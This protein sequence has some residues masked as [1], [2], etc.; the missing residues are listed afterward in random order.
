MEVRKT[1]RKEAREFIMEHHYTGTCGGAVMT[2]GLFNKYTDELLGAIAFQTP[3]SE[4]V[5]AYIFE[6]MDPSDGGVNECECDHFDEDHKYRQHVTELQRLVTLD[7]T[8][9]NTESWFIS[10]ALSKLKDHKPKYWAVVSFADTTEGHEGTIYKASNAYYYGKASARKFY[11]NDEG[12]L[13]SPRQGGV[14]IT[15]PEAREKGW[16]IEERYTK[17]RYL[18]LLP[19]PYQAKEELYEMV[20]CDLYPYPPHDEPLEEI[21]P[22]NS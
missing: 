7:K 2:W 3:I 18:F 15:I 11:R 6:D 10:R 8:P 17:H 14:N 16:E 1:G 9:K 5:R 4:N 13:L 20:E 22:L 19:D 12:E 21:E